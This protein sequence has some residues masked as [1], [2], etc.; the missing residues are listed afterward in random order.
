[1]SEWKENTG[2]VPEGVTA[3][4]AVEVEYADKVVVVWSANE[5]IYPND[6]PELWAIEGN[7]RD[8]VCWRFVDDQ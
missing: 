4:T 5:N 6:S 7:S 1:M 3:A 8:V 2:V